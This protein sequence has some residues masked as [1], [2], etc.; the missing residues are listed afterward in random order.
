MAAPLASLI[1][2]EGEL[3]RSLTEAETARAWTALRYA[4]NLVRAMAPW[5]S[6][7]PVP[8]GVLSVVSALAARR[9]SARLDGANSESVGPYSRSFGST[10]LGAFTAAEQLLL[11]AALGVSGNVTTSLAGADPS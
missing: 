4:S 11:A 1:D 8:D 7:S 10:D 2:L 6:F 9:F 3:G 5:A